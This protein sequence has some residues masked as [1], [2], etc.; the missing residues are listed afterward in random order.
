M[1]NIT[2]ASAGAGKTFLLTKTY[3]DML[4]SAHQAKNAHRRILAVTFT[5]KA[6]AEMKKRIVEELSKLARAEKSD[7]AAELKQ[8]FKLNDTQL[9]ER[10]QRILF[11]LLQDY[12]AFA[13]STIDS[14]FQQVIRAFSRELGLSGKYNLELDTK[15]IQQSAVD[16][17]FFSLSPKEDKPTFEAILSMI[18]D[19]LENDHSW[20]PKGDVLALSAELFKEVVMQNKQGL[21]ASLQDTAMVEAYKKQLYAVRHAYLKTYAQAAN[22]VKQYLENN[23][24]EYASFSNGKK[25]FAPLDYDYA[26]ILK[27]YDDIPKS[28]IKLVRGEESI[29][30]AA[31]KKKADM[32]MHEAALRQLVQPIYDCLAGPEMSQLLTANAILKNYSSLTLLAKVAACIDAKNKEL[33][34]LPISDTNALLNDVVQANAASPFIY[35]KIGTRIHHFLIDEFQD[36]SAMQWNSFRPLIEESLATEQDNLVV[37]DVK[38]SIYRFRNSDYSLMLRGIGQDFPQALLHNLEGNWRSAR[39]VVTFNNNLFGELSKVLNS[40]VNEVIDKH[41]QAYVDVIQ[42]VYEK[43]EQLPMLAHKAEA[44]HKPME[45]GYVQVQFTPLTKKEEW[46]KSVVEQL[47]QLLADIQARQIPLGRVACLIRNNKDALMIAETLVNAGYKVMSNEGL[48]LT[49]SPA[50]MF[51]ITY[52]RWITNRENAILDYEL[53]YF[54]EQLGIIIPVHTTIEIVTYSL[55]EQVQ[56]LIKTYE[57]DKQEAQRTYLLALLDAVYDYQNKYSSDVYSFLTWWENHGASLA[58]NMQETSDAIQLVSI[59]KS[60]GLEYDVVIIPFCDWAKAADNNARK[61]I[62]WVKAPENANL[63]ADEPLVAPLLLPISFNK[64]LA[65]TAFAE[66]YYRELL[67]LY[68]DNLNLTYVAFTRAKKE[69]YIFAPLLA[70]GK[71]ADNIGTELHAVLQQNDCEMTCREEYDAVVYTMGEKVVAKTDK[72]VEQTAKEQLLTMQLPLLSTKPT[73][74]HGDKKRERFALRLHSRDFFSTEDSVLAWGTLMHQILQQVRVRGDEKQVIAEMLRAGM[75]QANQVAQVRKQFVQFWQLIE[76]EGREAWYDTTQYTILNEQEIL[77]PGQPTARPD[78]ILVH[79]QHKHAIIIDY[80]FGHERKA[81]TIQVQKYMRFLSQM[82]Y[83]VEGY[84]CYV[85]L[86]KIID[87]ANA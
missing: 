26:D 2:R 58:L 61:N 13:V 52:L 39:S 75:L 59:H 35:E 16:D 55:F 53:R 68:L 49:A 54:A 19:N 64:Q 36:T 81:N 29:L 17:F 87:V 37:G 78:R 6:T 69:L 31:D 44:K 72:K 10:A 28:F 63:A 50:V 12:S 32:Q 4:F 56:M 21:F 80:K 51:I 82:G 73:Q 57:L 40:E 84:L 66:D 67:D 76:Q 46:R 60:K 5:K 38:Q 18:E 9:Q 30:K 85:A 41:C 7:F 8:T 86:Q 43:H 11:D 33:N 83:S 65:E 71:K 62:L 27:K 70:E 47:P 20:D 79:Q 15:V 45:E 74:E 23:G 3:I 1:L 25:V 42:S 34:R 77:I 48:K 24:L 14:F 22:K